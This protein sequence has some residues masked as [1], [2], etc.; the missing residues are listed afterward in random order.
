MKYFVDIEFYEENFLKNVFFKVIHQ[1]RIFNAFCQQYY[2]TATI[3]HESSHSVF[4]IK[5]LVN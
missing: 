5:L 4:S 3:N 2:D 1:N